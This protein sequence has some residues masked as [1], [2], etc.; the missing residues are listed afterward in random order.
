MRDDL[1]CGMVGGTW[2]ILDGASWSNRKWP[3]SDQPTPVSPT[4]L[5]II[6]EP[7]DE[8]PDVL[9]MRKKLGMC[10]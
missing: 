4:C 9:H 2:P 10:I 1:Q 8:K 7:R 5:S 6:M 3:L